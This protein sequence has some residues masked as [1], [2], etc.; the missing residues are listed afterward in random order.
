MKKI[1][2]ASLL[3]LSLP[4]TLNATPVDVANKQYNMVGRISVHGTGK[5]Y[6]HSASAG[7]VAPEDIYASISFGDVDET[8]GT[9]QWFDD[10]LMV[11]TTANG[12]ILERDGNKMTLQF[13]GQN[14]QAA[15]SA[16]F[17]LA[18]IPPTSGAGGS[19][20]VGKYSLT[21]V[22]TKKSVT[23]TESTS[24]SVNAASGC[25]FTWTIKRKMKGNV[26]TPI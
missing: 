17:T 19:V 23:V 20:S 8:G 18:N 26:V 11:A 14:A 15:G 12:D 13:T 16:L 9:F 3:A 21:A 6:G 10:S 4:M 25:T 2:V 7:K 5:C 1:V 24:M 22:A